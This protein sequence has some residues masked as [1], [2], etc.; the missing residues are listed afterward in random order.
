MTLPAV[1]C[2]MRLCEGH[3]RG[4]VQLHVRVLQP[5]REKRAACCRT[6]RCSP[7][8][9]G[10]TF[11][12]GT[13]GTSRIRFTC[14]CP[15]GQGGRTR[16]AVTLPQC[17]ALSVLYYSEHGGVDAAW[18]ALGREAKRAGRE[19]GG[20]A[21]VLGIVAPYPGGRSRR[22]GIASGWPCPWRSEGIFFCLR[23]VLFHFHFFC[24][25]R[26][27]FFPWRKKVSKERHLRKGGISDFP[28]P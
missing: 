8:R 1:T 14:A 20:S 15:S 22:S 16:D 24:L 11:W 26:D 27:T 25:W 5:V 9:T 3:L 13:S 17:R 10:G 4:Q 28:F 18:L 19:G 21:A 2:R 6:S 7:C 12:R 23:R